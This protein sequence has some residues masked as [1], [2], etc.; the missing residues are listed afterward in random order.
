MVVGACAAAALLAVV[1]TSA[2]ATAPAVGSVCRHANSQPGQATTSQIRKATLC[3]VNKARTDAGVTALK[4][5]SDLTRMAKHHTKTM[6]AQ[7]CLKHRCAGEPS[8]PKRLKG[9]GYLD[10]AVKWAYAE[11]LGY[12]STPRQ[13][14][15]RWLNTVLDS[16][17]LLSPTYG[18]VGIAPARGA[19]DTGV[20]DSAFE[21][22]TIDLGWRKLG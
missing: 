10:T 13:M 9:S 17:N 21:T 19:A 11:D 4:L 22:Y 20:N 1:T 12:E 2:S 8:L 5:N 7:N 15:S 3:L 14:V 18:D 6:L 16:K